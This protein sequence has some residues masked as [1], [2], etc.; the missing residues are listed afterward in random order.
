[1]EKDSSFEKENIMPPKIQAGIMGGCSAVGMLGAKFVAQEQLTIWLIGASCLLLFAILNNGLSIF[2]G[3]Y[4]NYL[5]HSVYSFIFLLIGSIAFA[6]VLSGLSVFEAGGYRT[7]F[8]IILA[9]NFI[10]ISM[11]MMIKSCLRMFAEKDQR[12]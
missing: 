3:D 9:A 5:I 8:L 2:S 6:T 7:I 4:R 12:L 10:F 11:I 1:M